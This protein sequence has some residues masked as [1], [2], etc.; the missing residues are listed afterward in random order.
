MRQ[1]QSES[2]SPTAWRDR[3]A[4]ARVCKELRP[5][6]VVALRGTLGAGKTAFVRGIAA[7]L[8]PQASVSSPTFAIM[9]EYRGEMPLFHFDL[10]RIGDAEELDGI[11]FEEFFEKARRHAHRV[12]RTGA[13]GAAAA[14]H[15]GHAGKPGVRRHAPH[16][17]GRGAAVMLIL[18]VD[19]T[20]GAASCALAPGGCAAGREL[21]QHRLHPQRNAAAP[22]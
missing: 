5:G 15:C 17:G 11:G 19:A 3:G 8:A 20:G 12:E 1:W 21:S 16:H 10:Y 4:G 14:H 7:Q 2:L 9:N 18:A 6:D 13:A 22:D